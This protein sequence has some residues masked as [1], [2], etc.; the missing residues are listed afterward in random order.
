LSRLVLRVVRRWPMRLRARL[1]LLKVSGIEHD[2]PR[3]FVGGGGRDDFAAKPALAQQ[4][5][6]SAMI[7]VGMRQQHKI[8]AGRVEAKVA[9]IF[10]G[11]LAATLIEPTINQHTPAG[12]LDEVARTRHV[13]I[14]PMK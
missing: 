7:E 14:S 10:F 4:R 11:D 2:Q 6:P 13:A 1:L 3:E 5:Q 8:Y 9:G 12:A